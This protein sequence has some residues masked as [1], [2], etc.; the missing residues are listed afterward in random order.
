MIR[1]TNADYPLFSYIDRFSLLYEKER[2]K[3]CLV[4]EIFFDEIKKEYKKR[5]RGLKKDIE[6][7]S[8]IDK[9][10]RVLKKNKNN[11][12]AIY[13]AILYREEP[14]L[15]EIIFQ[16]LIYYKTEKMTISDEIFATLLNKTIPVYDRFMEF[17]GQLLD[18]IKIDEKGRMGYCEA[19]IGIYKEL[20]GAEMT[21]LKY[22]KEKALKDE[23]NIG[24]F[25]N[26][27]RCYEFVYVLAKYLKERPDK[28]KLEAAIEVLKAFP[29]EDFNRGGLLV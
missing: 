14:V 29:K 11:N 21:R 28:D 9:C 6:N 27:Q 10:V 26:G 5:K 7:T 22:I 15:L 18:S 20:Y 4:D 19:E 2:N 23:I 3:L 17:T 8:D 25:T 16:T 24:E 12:R 13:A 1:L